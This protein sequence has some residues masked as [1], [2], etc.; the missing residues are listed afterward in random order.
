MTAGQFAA[1]LFFGFLSILPIVQVES[2]LSFALKISA[3]VVLT[4]V[5]GLAIF[6]TRRNRAIIKDAVDP[7]PASRPRA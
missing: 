7:P 4:N 2:R 6:L 1:S 3:V 5:A